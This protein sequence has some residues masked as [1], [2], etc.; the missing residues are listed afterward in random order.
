MKNSSSK[1]SGKMDMLHGSLL[2]KIL[3][4]AM[5][6]AACSILQQLF[7]SVGTAVVGRF[8]SSEALAAVGSNSSVISLMVTLFSGISLG[9]NVVI[10][11]YIGQCDKKRVPRVVHTAVT[12]ALLSGVFLLVLGQFVAHPILVLMGAPKNIIHLATLYLRIYFLGMPF[13]MLYDFGASI[14]R[15]IG[16]TRRPMYALIVS[17][18]VNVILNLLFVVVFR[19][20]VAGAGL[21]TVGANAVSAAQ[22]IYFLMHEELPSFRFVFLFSL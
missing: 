1:Q 11:N 22:I 9:S 8:A 12:L 2:D 6:L 3:L 10:A 19:M 7:N 16:D 4:F 21:A 15:S 18:V 13:F 17:G 14:L 20:G 5:P